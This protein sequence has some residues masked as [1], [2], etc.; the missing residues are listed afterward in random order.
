[1]KI[2]YLPGSI[3]FL[4][5]R[6]GL[7]YSGSI[8][9]S[10]ITLDGFLVAALQFSLVEFQGFFL[11]S[12]RRIGHVTLMRLLYTIHS[13]CRT[14]TDKYLTEERTPLFILQSVDG[15]DFLAVHVCQSEYRLDSIKAFTELALVKQHYHIGVVDDGLLDNLRPDDVL[16]LLCD[17]AH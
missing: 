13:A 15:K 2:Q 12:F 16:N 5:K 3:H 17:H 1:M 7:A 8:P 10:A 11:G 9:V 6:Q 14:P 4:G